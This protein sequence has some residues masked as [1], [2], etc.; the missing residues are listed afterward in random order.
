MWI[1]GVTRPGVMGPP[2]TTQNGSQAS[3][4]ILGTIKT[5]SNWRKLAGMIELII[6]MIITL[7]ANT[8]NAVVEV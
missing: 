7:S 5:D 4:I 3:L 2:G 1:I 6:L 8:K